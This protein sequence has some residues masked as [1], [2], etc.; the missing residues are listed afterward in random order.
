MKIINHYNEDLEKILTAVFGFVGIAA[1][2]INLDIKGYGNE[3]WL[4]A[5][6]DIAGLIVVLAV[7][8]AAIRISQKSE[9]HYEM[10]RNALQRLQVKHPQI[11]MG[12]RY[13]REGYDPEKGKGLEYLFV[14]N[15]NRKSTLRAKLIPI[16]PLEEGCLYIY[17]QTATLAD[18][19]NYGRGNV[20][21]E[22]VSKVKEAVK[23]AVTSILNTNYKGKFESLPEV[24]DSVIAV[25]FNESEM[26][27]KH[28]ARAISDCTEAATLKLLEFRK[29]K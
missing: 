17:I 15:E 14:T 5:I 13:N 7:F 28:F 26:R 2:F 25:D 8:L 27:K 16:Q 21:D 6:K 4:D 23:D 10:A 18:A 19:L 20:T 24:K 29:L 11:L 12:P 22:D 3:N 9:T 1:I